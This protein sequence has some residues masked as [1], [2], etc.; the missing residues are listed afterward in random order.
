[1]SKDKKRNEKKKK[2]LQIISINIQSQGK[3]K[4]LQIILTTV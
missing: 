2:A 4:I 3:K 1:M